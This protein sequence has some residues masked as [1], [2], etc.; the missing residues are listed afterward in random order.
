LSRED[1]ESGRDDIGWYGSDTVNNSRAR[2]VHIVDATKGP[3]IGDG[4]L[5]RV[6]PFAVTATISLIVTLPVMSW[7]RPG[8][9]AIGALLAAATIIAAI[10][11][12]WNRVARPAQLVPP[13]LFLAATLLLASATGSGIGSP[14]I[15]LAVLPLMWLAIYEN[16]AAVL[17]A[18][19]S[20]GLA[21]WLAVP[22]GRQGLSLSHQV[23]VSTAVFVICGVGM[24]VTLHGLVAD[25]RRL[26]SALRERQ[27]AL[28]DAAAM[29]DALPERV[30]RYRLADHAITY[31]NAAWAAQ[32]HVDPDQA[33]GRPLEEFLSEDDLTGLESQ[34]ALLGPDNPIVVDSVARAVPDAPGQWLQWVDRYLAGPDG[35]E[36]LSIGRDVTER[37][38]AELKLAESEAR[39]RTLADKSADVVWRFILEPTPHFDYMSPSVENIL[40]YP[41]S[42]FLE[43]FG[44]VLEILDESGTSAV[45]RALRGEQ[46]LERFDF[47]FRH[48]NGSIVIGETRTAVVRGGLQGVSRD[49]TELRQLQ[50][51]MEAHA[52]RDS[53]TG[54]A[55]RRLFK[56][57]LDADLARTQ[58]SGRPLAVAFL[59]LDDFKTV[60]DTYGHDVGDLVL[61][62]TARRL[63]AIVRGADTVARLGGDEFVIVFEPNDASS[64]NLVERIDRAL[65][66]PIVVSP[67]EVVRCPASIGVADTRT[68]GCDAA[69]LLAAADEAMYEVKR[70]RQATREADDK[71]VA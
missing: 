6:L 67:T 66:A 19:L 52:L 14:F 59:D 10:V 44:R 1:E 35:A 11:F 25:T 70:A 58:R 32:Y 23:H 13:M 55:N 9:A 54:L 37:H 3:L 28:E 51:T 68:V 46:I 30:N 41:P 64:Y 34:L 21:L 53:L 18:A 40:G 69:A 49:V 36:V 8:L 31:C 65:S 2:N 29:L 5:Q 38:D 33:V 22:A 27:V 39:F 57:L 26:A 71:R 43:D 50:R 7:I 15:T 42:Y 56:E 4:R 60:N 17:F 24:G 12:P 47:H 16:R 20:G 63:L 48:A 61:C 45:G 62:E